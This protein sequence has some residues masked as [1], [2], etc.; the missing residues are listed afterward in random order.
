[1]SGD[2]SNITLTCNDGKTRSFAL[3]YL[4]WNDIHDNSQCNDCFERF[5]AFDLVNLKPKFESHSCKSGC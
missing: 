4:I 1:M 3:L 5:G 2:N